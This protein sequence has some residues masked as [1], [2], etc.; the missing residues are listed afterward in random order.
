MKELES[1]MAK[2]GRLQLLMLHPA[3]S[4]FLEKSAIE[5]FPAGRDDVQEWRAA[6]ER[7]RQRHRSHIESSLHSIDDWRA[8]FGIERVQC[9]LYGDTPLLYGFMYDR[10]M[11]Y[12]SSYFV[13]PIAR[14]FDVPALGLTPEDGIVYQVLEAT[15]SQWFE[16]KFATGVDPFAGVP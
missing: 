7:A 4:G 10:A 9:R 12:V 1:F 15:M 14:G 2:G 11:L 3:S 16:V 5:S 6:T 13:D 8:R